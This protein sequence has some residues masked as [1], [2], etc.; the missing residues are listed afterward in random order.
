MKFFQKSTSNTNVSATETQTILMNSRGGL[1]KGGINFV[2]W[3]VLMIIS[4]ILMLG[5]SVKFTK[6]LYHDYNS[7]Q[8]LYTGSCLMIVGWFF[9]QWP[10]GLNFIFAVTFLCYV[11]FNSGIYE[12]L[13]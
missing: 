13:E 1:N 11:L 9:L 7:K 2:T 10:F 3:F 4:F 8:Y 12:R 6:G 5:S